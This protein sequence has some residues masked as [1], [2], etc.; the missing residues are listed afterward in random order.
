MPSMVV[1]DTEPNSFI[2][3]I[4]ILNGGSSSDSVS[5][6]YE[7]PPAGSIASLSTSL[8]NRAKTNVPPM[9]LADLVNPT[10]PTVDCLVTGNW[11]Q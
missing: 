3:T 10:G 4:V 2:I 11:S 5:S 9:V 1:M 6:R 7:Y 8:S